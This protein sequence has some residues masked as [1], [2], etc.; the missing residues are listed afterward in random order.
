MAKARTIYACQ[1]C[2]AQSP[3][4][5]GRCPE[6]QGWNTL[7]EE[8]LESE[9]AA[10]RRPAKAGKSTTQSLAA[11]D[12]AAEARLHTGIGE[13]DRVLGGGVVP[14]SAVLIGGDPGIGK[15]TL[16]LQAA[17]ALSTEIDCAYISGEESVDQL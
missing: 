11:V 4:W 17:A 7:A 13:L 12:N 10:T 6:C 15:S 2:G 8:R 9:T 3:G 1:S 5:L 14:G 16:L